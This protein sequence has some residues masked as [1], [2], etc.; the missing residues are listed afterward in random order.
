MTTPSLQ[1]RFALLGLL[2]ACLGGLVGPANAQ[3]KVV[4]VT[5]N[6]GEFDLQMLELAT[7]KTVTNF[8]GYVQ[9]GDYDNSI[10]HRSMPGFVVQGGGFRLKGDKLDIVPTK[11]PV[12]NEFRFPNERGTVAM[13][14]EDKKPNSATSQWFINLS[15]NSTNL[16]DQNGGFTVFAIVVGNG[17]AVA[18]AIA[19]LDVYDASKQLGG[20]FSDLP[21]RTNQLTPDSLVLLRKVRSL[22]AGSRVFSYNFAKSNEG[23]T[24]GFADLPANHNAADYALQS[25]RTNLPANLAGTNRTQALYISGHDRSSDLWMFWKRKAVGLRPGTVY[26]ATFDV[27]LASSARSGAV[28]VGGSPGQSVTIKA[29]ASAAEPK[30]VRDNKAWLRLNIDKGNQGKGGAAASVLGHAAKA[31][32]SS[33]AFSMVRRDNRSGRL[34]VKSA[35]DGS[36]WLFFGSDSGFAGKTSLYY[37]KFTAVL[38]PV[39]K[40]QTITFTRPGPAKI[41]AKPPALL[42]TASSKLPVSYTSR[43]PQVARIEMGKI[44]LVG[45]GEARIIASQ[46]GN[47]QWN[48]APSVEQKLTVTKA[49]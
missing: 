31:D 44:V 26:E 41:G 8:L 7:P 6:M 1:K 20:V 24:A 29:G 15:D 38:E 36:L 37:T 14:K 21:L 23:F 32:N 42:A 43:D 12:T 11:P 27:E 10:I 47:L 2:L 5:G 13:A 28:G 45:P 33:D 39:G 22:A 35:A 16:D 48:A 9:R 46:A 19:G 49:K 17:M 3:E 25:T 34:R 30:V 40:N 4:R 18:D